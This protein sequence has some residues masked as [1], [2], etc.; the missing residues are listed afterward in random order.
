MLGMD[1]TIPISN[2]FCSRI[3]PCSICNS[4][5]ARIFLIVGSGLV[6]DFEFPPILLISSF[7]IFPEELPLDKIS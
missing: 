2:F 3:L 4:K 7:K 6:S 5:Q 1:L